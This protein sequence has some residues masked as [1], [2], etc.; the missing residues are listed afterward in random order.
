MAILSVLER[1]ENGTTLP[2]PPFS[3]ARSSRPMRV[4]EDIETVKLNKECG[5]TDPRDRRRCIIRPQERTIV[6][7]WSQ[8]T[9][10]WM[11]G[12][13]PRLSRYESYPFPWTGIEKFRIDVLVSPP[14]SMAVWSD[15]IIHTI[16]VT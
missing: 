5:M 6:L 10:P 3:G 8:R 1:A 2:R 12:R 7:H 11:N 13:S 4:G 15:R 16:I 14:V 9:A